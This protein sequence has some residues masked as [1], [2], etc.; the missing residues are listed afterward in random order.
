MSYN[1]LYKLYKK[2]E[3]VMHNKIQLERM[4]MQANI[5]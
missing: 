1:I 3:L 2:G 4:K 5:L